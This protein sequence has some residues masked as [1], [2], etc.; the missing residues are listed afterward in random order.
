MRNAYLLMEI[1]VKMEFLRK[2]KGGVWRG[3]FLVLAIPFAILLYN[4]FYA[5]FKD[6]YQTLAVTG[7]ETALLGLIFLMM[8]VLFIF[9]GFVPAINSFYLSENVEAYLPLPLKPYQIMLGKAANPLLTIYLWNLTITAPLLLMYMLQADSGV[10]FFLY[11]IVIWATLPILPFVLLSTLLMIVMR[12]INISKYKDRAKAMG[13]IL[14]FLFILGI[15]IVIRQDNG[16]NDEDVLTPMLQEGGLLSYITT[17]VPNA[18]LAAVAL[19]NPLSLQGLLAFVGFLSITVLGIFF[20]LYFSEK[21]Y[22][23][24]VRGLSGGNRSSSS[25]KKRGSK[26]QSIFLT[27]SFRDIKTIIRTPVFFTQII[28]HQFFAPLFLLVLL[29]LESNS[30]S[31]WRAGADDLNGNA[32]LAILLGF[33]AVI[34]ATSTASTSSFSREGQTLAHFRY[35]PVTFEQLLYSKVAVAWTVPA[36][37]MSLFGVAFLVFV[38][39]P[40]ILWVSWLLFSYMILFVTTLIGVALDTD[41]PK[42]HWSSEEEVFQHRLINLLLLLFA[43]FAFAPMLLLLWKLPYMEHLLVSLPFVFI[44]LSLYSYI[45]TRIL[46]K[47]AR[48]SFERMSG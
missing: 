25:D 18:E 34:G 38:P 42:L 15:N 8:T 11:V 9:T 7:N 20:F 13:G 1:M 5:L 4:L 36:L 33:S 16:G 3:L 2:E 40:L 19:G 48:L 29:F 21:L 24:G 26:Q 46:K 47:R 28:G 12:F 41:N 39:L 44:A 31:F 10:V 17:Y 32:V 22:F 35:V 37:A 6:M 27:L 45:G 43:A 14:S 23:K 30:F